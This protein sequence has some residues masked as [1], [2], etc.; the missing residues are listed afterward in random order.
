[1]GFN[2]FFGQCSGYFLLARANSTDPSV[3]FDET[4]GLI[5]GTF[6]FALPYYP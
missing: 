3:Y 6:C 2:R 4:L 5:I 1:M